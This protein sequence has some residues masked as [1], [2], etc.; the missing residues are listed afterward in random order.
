[1]T[2]YRATEQNWDTEAPGE[3]ETAPE[4][5]ALTQDIE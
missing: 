4:V 3:D 5:E 2:E 1:V